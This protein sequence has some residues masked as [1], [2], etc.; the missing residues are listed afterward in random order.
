MYYPSLLEELHQ[1][2]LPRELGQLIKL[3]VLIKLP[4]L[5]KSSNYTATIILFCLI[6]YLYN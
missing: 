3:Q 1:E 6:Q 5:S 2:L 4:L